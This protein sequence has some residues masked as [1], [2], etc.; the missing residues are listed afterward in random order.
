MSGD[1]VAGGTSGTTWWW[2]RGGEWLVSVTRAGTAAR[3]SFGYPCGYLPAPRAPIPRPH[4]PPHPP[5]ETTYLYFYTFIV[6][7]AT[8]I[9]P[10]LPTFVIKDANHFPGTS[11]LCFVQRRVMPEGSF[12]FVGKSCTHGCWRIFVERHRKR[13]KYNACHGVDGLLS[14]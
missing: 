5:G 6:W 10:P 2:N 13:N 9:K 1:Q 7:P 12:R 3:V 14:V 4:P 11:F 8:Y